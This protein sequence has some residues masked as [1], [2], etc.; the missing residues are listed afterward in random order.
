MILSHRHKFIFFCNGRTGTTSIEQALQPL[1]EGARYAFRALDLFVAKHVPPA[2][3][4][5][6]LPDAVWSGYF[7]FVF[8]RNPFDWF[9]SQWRHNFRLRQAA[10]APWVSK[11]PDGRILYLG[12][13]MEELALKET[14]DAEDAELLW[15]FLAR[16]HRA[17]PGAEGLLQSNFVCDADG[18][19]IVDFVGRF[20][21]LAPDFAQVLARLG[22]DLPLPHLARTSHRH[23]AAH[24]TPAA[25][26]RVAQLWGRDFEL[27]G[28]PSRIESKGAPAV[29]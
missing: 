1:D 9:V 7:K 15:G 8:V 21:T 25:A 2:I 20:E 26:A 24:F 12:R 10:R 4:R 3:L 11:G 22:L 14:F 19:Q 13:P 16:Y 17:L 28:Y 23:Y 29:P 5:G 18:R 27:F 6:C